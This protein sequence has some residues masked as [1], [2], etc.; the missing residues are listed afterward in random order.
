MEFFSTSII[1][2]IQI[3]ESWHENE[4]VIFIAKKNEKTKYNHVTEDDDRNSFEFS[5][6]E[7]SLY[8]DSNK[9]MGSLWVMDSYFNIE[10]IKVSDF[11]IIISAYGLSG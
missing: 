10:Q 2:L 7:N 9:F 8:N 5:Y 11:D 6:S 1:E 3:D 4:I